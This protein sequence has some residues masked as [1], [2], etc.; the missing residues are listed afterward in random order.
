MLPPGCRLRLNRDPLAGR[1]W[2]P[3]T[4]E[5]RRDAAD[6]GHQNLCPNRQVRL[7]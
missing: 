3:Q 7:A 1:S 4:D 6:S 2:P 5:F